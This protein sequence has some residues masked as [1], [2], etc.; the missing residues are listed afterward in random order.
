LNDLALLRLAQHRRAEA[1]TL[2]ARAFTLSEARLR[3][4]AL[5]LSESRLASFLQMLRSDEERLYS[6]LRAYRGDPGVRRLAL[7]AAL[8]LKGRSLDEL[9]DTSRTIHRSLD[10]RDHDAFARLR[11]LRT[12]ITR[13]SLDSRGQTTLDDSQRLMD[14]AE[15]GDALEADL[16]T[17]SAPLR[18][19]NALPPPGDMVDR[20]AATLPRDAALVE[21][22]AYVDR[23][24]VPGRGTPRSKIP[25]QLCYLMLVLFPD[26]RIRAV[27]LGPAA[28]IDSAAS[29]LRDTLASRDAGYQDA[30]VGL[31]RLVFKPLLPL[32]GNIRKLFVAPDGQLALVPIAAL[33]DGH[34]FL[35]DTFDFTY[36]TSG[37]DLLPRPDGTPPSTSVAIL[38]DPDYGM[39][40]AAQEPAP[41]GGV[42]IAMAERSHSVERFFSGDRADLSGQRWPRLPGT[43]QEAEAIHQLLSQSRVFLG[44]DASKERLLHL[45][46]P[47]ILHIAA[48]GYFLEDSAAPPGTRG[49]GESGLTGGGPTPHLPDPLLRSGLVLAGASS[50]PANQL[51]SSFIT[52][53]EL[54]GLNLWGTQL[55]VLSA[56]DTGR[57]DIKRGQ[58]VYGLRRALVAAG[59]ETLVVSLWKV[60]DDVTRILMERYYLNL[61]AGQGRAA[62]LREAMLAIRE[63]HPDPHFWAPFI[64]IGRD[65]PLRQIA[66]SSQ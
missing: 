2:F 14:L 50:A 55:V 3:K 57:G 43:R 53:L 6:V 17:R 63:Q 65:T 37:R 60:D 39:A 7:T 8:L 41:D 38:A 28:P 30:A 21:L 5:G 26:G 44:A 18:A 22:V 59:A 61:L 29:R 54:A 66:P 47:G 19:L 13:L 58:G 52:A 62:A 40:P 56:C 34:Q 36:L 9:A 4:E 48:H 16:A 35:A 12:Q 33:H 49:L 24:L 51:G 10:T 31:Y 64:A 46:T 42:A 27:D 1:V 25:D 45:S 11:S 15:Q 32:L 23:P 20:V